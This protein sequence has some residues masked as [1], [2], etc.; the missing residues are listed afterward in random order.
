MLDKVKVIVVV[1]ILIAIATVG[2]VAYE[3][4]NDG[5]NKTYD[6]NAALEVY[7]NANGDYTINSDDQNIIKQ[8]ISGEL[9]FSD[10]PLAD[11]NYDGSVTQT[12]VDLVSKIINR[13]NCTVYHVN[14]CSTGDYVASTAWP[15][16]SAIATGAANMLLF[17]TE[18]GTKNMIHGITYSV[19]SPP[20][21]TLFPTFSTMTSLGSSSTSMSVDAAAD[22]IAKYDVTALISD[23]T[24]S[25]IKNESEF[26]NIGVDVIRI[27]PAIVDADEAC[28]QLLLIGFLFQTQTQCMKICEWQTNLQ[29]YINSELEGTEKVT[30]IT[31]NGST[32]K[33]AWISGGNS[34]YL[35]V[36]KAAGG[37]Y[38]LDDKMLTDYSSGA[39]FGEGDT[40]L[41]NYTFDYIVSIRTNGWYS[42]TVDIGEKY[43]S[44]LEYLT[45]TEAYEEGNA[46]VIVG[47]APIPIRIAY[48][49]S[50]LY[51]DIFSQEWADGIN[52]EFFE[53]FYDVDI[54]F[55]GLFFVISESMVSS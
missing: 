20:D 55:T 31:S 14:T 38:A 26:E 19:S 43:N 1:V 5:N 40:W 35:D 27:A 11:A 53:K 23:K 21:S 28:S 25:T 51:P 37:I 34:D 6:I 45:H 17:L 16:K 22:T 41:Y 39:Y 15:I 30:V 7:G 52:Q 44:S 12:D 54:D 32:S 13:D 24:A 49:A 48:T 47:D 9:S 8:I 42:G 4:T 2:V 29:K 3:M 36:M 50:V 33:G 18:A 10:Y 46:Y